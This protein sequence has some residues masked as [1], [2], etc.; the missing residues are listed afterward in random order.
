MVKNIIAIGPLLVFYVCTA[1]T[2]VFSDP[3]IPIDVANG[4]RFSIELSS[5]ATTGYGWNFIAPVD[6][7]TIRLVKANYRNPDSA[8]TGA[9]GTQVWVLEALQSDKTTI[10][11]EYKRSWETDPPSQTADFTVSIK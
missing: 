3:S 6:E 10:A 4:S 5:N 2:G 7:N 1:T 8:L 11:L 9:G